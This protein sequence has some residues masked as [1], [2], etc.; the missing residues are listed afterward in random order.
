MTV[1]T[2]EYTTESGDVD[3]GF[4]AD[5]AKYAPFG[6]TFVQSGDFGNLYWNG[7]LVD[8]LIDHSPDGLYTTIGAEDEGGITI[9]T[10]Y[11]SNG[12]LTGVE[13]VEN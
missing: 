13:A 8:A 1:V 11:D 4:M 7:E 5:M 3:A 9:Q 10:V 2:D 12:K 6:V